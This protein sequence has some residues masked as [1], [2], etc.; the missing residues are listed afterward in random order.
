MNK[1]YINNWSIGSISNRTSPYMAP[2]EHKLHLQGDRR[3]EGE[4]SADAEG[5]RTSYIVSVQGK[6]VHTY[7]GSVYILEDPD[8]DYLEYLAQINYPYNKENPISC[9]G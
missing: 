4:S 2:E 7:S 1:Y 8:P 5:I 3:R 6:E 9:K